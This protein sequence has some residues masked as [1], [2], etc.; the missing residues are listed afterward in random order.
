[1]PHNLASSFYIYKNTLVSAVCWAIC[2][3]VSQSKKRE[4]LNED[5]DKSFDD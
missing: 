4:I 2:G 1:M 3:V 5:N